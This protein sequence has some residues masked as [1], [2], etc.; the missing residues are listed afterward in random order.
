MNLGVPPTA[1][2]ARTGELTPPGMTPWARAKSCSLV[3]MLACS[4]DTPRRALVALAVVEAAAGFARAAGPAGLFASFAIFGAGQGPEETVGHDV[5][6]A[7]AEARVQALV[8][9]GQRFAHGGLQFAA[10]SQ[11]RG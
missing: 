6:H 11:Q 3:C 8:E 2:K 10:G 9:E 4:V 5:A 7:R 1:R